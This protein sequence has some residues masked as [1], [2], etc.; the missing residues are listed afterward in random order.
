MDRCGDICRSEYQRGNTKFQQLI[1]N[2]ILI[3]IVS[4][5]LNALINKINVIN[6]NK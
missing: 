6:V 3:A 4:E 5:D 1:N 2:S